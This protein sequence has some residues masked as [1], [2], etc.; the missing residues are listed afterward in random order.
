MSNSYQHAK[1]THVSKILV[2]LFFLMS[3]QC[4]AAYK[5]KTL[6]K[7]EKLSAQFR[8]TYTKYIIDTD[9]WLT[10]DITI[11]ED[12]IL[13]FDGGSL[14]GPHAL[15][16]QNTIIK[17]SIV[18]IFDVDIKLAGTWCITEAYPEWFGAR[19]DGITDCTPAFNA[20]MRL[21][22]SQGKHD[23]S[24]VPIK[25]SKGVYV[26]ENPIVLPFDL[27]QY[28]YN[29]NNEREIYKDWCSSFTLI[30]SGYMTTTLKAGLKNRKSLF[31]SENDREQY[32]S[33]HRLKNLVIKDLTFSGSLVCPT[34]FDNWST[35]QIFNNEFENV[36]FTEFSDVAVDVMRL[37]DEKTPSGQNSECN[38][39]NVSFRY[40][41]IGMRFNGA[42]SSFYGCR[43]ERNFYRGLVVTGFA[44][45][46][47][48]YE[49]L[50]QYNVSIDPEY[51]RMFEENNIKRG[52]FPGNLMFENVNDAHVNFHGSYFEPSIDRVVD[53]NYPPIQILQSGDNYCR[54]EINIEDCYYNMFTDFIKIIRTDYQDD[55]KKSV[56]CYVGNLNL[57][58]LKIARSNTNAYVLAFHG[59]YLTILNSFFSIHNSKEKMGHV[60]LDSKK[61]YDKLTTVYIDIPRYG[62]STNRPNY[63]IGLGQTYFDSDLHKLLVR[64]EMPENPNKQVWADA[65]GTVITP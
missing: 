21:C 42:S 39:R 58:N 1:A 26:L 57:K 19:N 20:L 49:S 12:C 41:H 11:P 24:C 63:L 52:D 61:N 18:K 51:E 8:E 32:N 38:W 55:T 14:K 23:I 29:K 37:G 10:E 50:I 64:V 5:V 16:G 15:I 9:L 34:C 62:S 60:V 56:Q 47:S 3:M 31:T 48:F 46:I 33:I 40:N 43:W 35:L 59:S 22:Y 25:L 28:R 44:T 2:F 13:C 36:T 65:N 54:S 7:N 27:N 4:N 30:G 17:S 45:S 53:V 6:K